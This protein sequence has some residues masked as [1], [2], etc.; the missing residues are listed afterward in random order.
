MVSTSQF[1]EFVFFCH[2][3][4]VPA[5]FIRFILPLIFGALIPFHLLMPILTFIYPSCPPLWCKY[6]GQLLNW[7]HFFPLVARTRPSM[8]FLCLVCVVLFCNV[9]CFV[10]DDI[11]RLFRFF[12]L[13]VLLALHLPFLP[14]LPLLRV[15]NRKRSTLPIT[16]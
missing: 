14:L 7:A 9:T 10:T 5:P 13:V 16:K 8:I 12:L 3:C 15:A 2:G 11:V 1:L 6:L 4:F